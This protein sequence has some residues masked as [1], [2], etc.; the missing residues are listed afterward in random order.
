MIRLCAVSDLD[1]PGSKGFHNE[2]GHLFAVRQGLQVFV[3]VNSCPHFG[4]NLEW[5]PDQFLD[6]EKRLI[7]CATHG[8]QFLIETGEC[9]AGPCPGDQLTSVEC[10][11]RDGVVYL[12]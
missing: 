9:I 8:A 11:V 12:P 4:I 1:D 5:Q 2:R 7:Q 6:S 3:Y 10:E